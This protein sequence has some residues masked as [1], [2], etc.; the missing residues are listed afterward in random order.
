M[1]CLP[2]GVAKGINK[3]DLEKIR[4][5]VTDL[6]DFALF[7]I[8]LFKD[9]VLKNPTY[10]DLILKGPYTLEVQNMG[11]VDENNAPN[12]YHGK[13]RVVDFAGKEICKYEQIGRASCRERV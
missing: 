4:P 2:G 8:Q 3:E 10:V 7:S 5:L 11:L 1:W 6:Y 9:V 12:F 13:V